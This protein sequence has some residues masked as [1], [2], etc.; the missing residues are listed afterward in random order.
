MPKDG[1]EC[2]SFTIN[3]IDSLL[4][5]ENKYYLKVYLSNC[6]YK[7]V[8]TQIVYYLDDNFFLSLITIRLIHVVLW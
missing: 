7:I 8:N 1:V 5:Y 3:S 2:E 4:A 6:A